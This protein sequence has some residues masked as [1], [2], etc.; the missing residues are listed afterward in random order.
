M[1][2]CDSSVTTAIISSALV[3]HTEHL[4]VGSLMLPKPRLIIIS[5]LSIMSSVR[6][7]LFELCSVDSRANG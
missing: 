1:R 7:R 2:E 5:H 3:V 6:C 4:A